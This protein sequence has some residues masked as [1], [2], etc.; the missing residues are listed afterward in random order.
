MGNFAKPIREI[1]NMPKNTVEEDSGFAQ[2]LREL[3]KKHEALKAHVE[4]LQRKG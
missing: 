2:R 3:E 4:G 1:A